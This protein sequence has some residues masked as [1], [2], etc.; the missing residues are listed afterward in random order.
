MLRLIIPKKIAVLEVKLFGVRERSY[1]QIEVVAVVGAVIE[2]VVISGRV[3]QTRT[4]LKENVETEIGSQHERSIV[5]CIVSN[6]EVS[7]RSL[8]RTSFQR[9]MRV[10]HSGSNIKSRIGNSV[11]ADFAVVVRN[12][13]Q[14]PFDGVVGVGA[15]IHILRTAF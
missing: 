13:F 15:F 10:H 5:V 4:R 7:D 1:L 6:I 12:I 3:L 11:G 8:R 2:A 14:Q 9:G